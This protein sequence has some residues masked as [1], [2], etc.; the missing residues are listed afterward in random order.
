MQYEKFTASSVDRTRSF[1]M[2]P[3][4]GATRI[5]DPEEDF[6]PSPQASSNL[7]LGRMLRS[8]SEAPSC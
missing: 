6:P 5:K 8:A 1:A 2:S 7:Y 3:L 4:D